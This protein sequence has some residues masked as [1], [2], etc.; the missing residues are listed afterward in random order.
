MDTLEHS[1]FDAALPYISHIGHDLPPPRIIENRTFDE[2][3]VGDAAQVVRTFTNED[4]ELFASVSGDVNPTH[5][6]RD[7]AEETMFH[8]VV[9]HGMLG[10]SMFST[11]LG[12]LLPGPGTIF[13]GQD[14]HFRGPVKPGDTLT[15][16]VVV[17]ATHPE[18]K[19]VVLDCLCTNQDGEAVICG[20]AEVIAPTEKVRRER[21]ALPEVSVIHHQ[22][23]ADLLR[24]AGGHPPLP[25]AI[26]HPCDRDSL[27]GALDAAADGFIA[28]TLVGPESK[29]RAAAAEAGL[30]IAEIEIVNTGHSHEAAEVAVGLARDGRVKA[31]MKGS[32]HTDELMHEVMRRENRLRT[33][34]RI[35]HAYVML[36]ASSGKPLILSDC[37]INIAPGLEDKVDIVQN[38]IDLALALGI[39]APKV[40]VL[41]AVETVT[42]TMPSTLDAAALCKMADRGQIKGG[43]LDGPLAFDNAINA[44]AA[45]TKGIAS[46]VAGHP[47]ILIVPNLE[48]GNILAK[49][50]S[51]SGGADAA[52]VVLGAAVPII[53]TSRADSVRTRL[54]S[55]AVAALA[56]R[57]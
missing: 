55:C 5:L 53:L 3:S 57:R 13:V 27:K 25:T 52:G 44:A 6:D 40:A 42:P 1:S 14:L 23:Y 7:Y 56:A 34:R 15:A 20:N 28:P 22:A 26:V 49:Q 41:S 4:I 16:K 47:D 39:A 31:L 2:I 8:G 46:A 10:G 54:A 51:F 12:T 19:R 43:V 36:L 17:R 11:V 32:L 35:S 29:I 45:L 33:A 50:M 30:D 9:A 38:A 37:A 18:K 48:A 21:V 24:R